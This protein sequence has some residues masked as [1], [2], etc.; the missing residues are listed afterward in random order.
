MSLVPLPTITKNERVLLFRHDGFFKCRKFYTKHRA[1]NCPNGF[2]SG[3]GYK[4]LTEAAA[5]AA[6][7]CGVN[8]VMSANTVGETSNDHF[9]TITA[10]I[11]E[12]SAVLGDG[13]NSDEYMNTLSIPHLYWNCFSNGPSTSLPIWI[14]ELIDSS[15]NLVII[16]NS[17]ATKL[18]LRHRPLLEPLEIN[19]AMG[20]GEV[21]CEWKIGLYCHYFQFV[22][23]G[24][25][26]QFAL[27][28]LINS[29]AL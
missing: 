29:Y 9:A 8:T 27:L 17:L 14:R 25:H 20:W 13:T 19:L 3:D 1:A 21:L 10:V 2:P 23:L 11:L 22:L 16:D 28:L 5:L 15:S 24:K 6:C 12:F 4:V 26:A 7:P 18:T